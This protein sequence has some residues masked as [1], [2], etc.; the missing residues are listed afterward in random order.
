MSQ[1]P[2]ALFKQKYFCQ[3]CNRQCRDKD[4][5]NCHLKSDTHRINMEQVAENPDLYINNY[6][7]E[8]Q[9]GFLDILK[10]G[11]TNVW[12][13]ANKIYQEYIT[14]KFAT[15]LNATKWTTLT[16]FIKSMESKEKLEIK[17][18]EKEVLIR[19]REDQK[20][21]EKFLFQKKLLEQKN[22]E[23]KRNKELSKI[24]SRANEEKNKES[25]NLN[26]TQNEDLCPEKNLSDSKDDKIESLVDHEK[27]KNISIQLKINKS[28]EIMKKPI[29]GNIFEQPEFLCKKRNKD[30]IFGMQQENVST[31]V[32]INNQFNS[33]EKDNL[34]MENTKNLL[35]LKEPKSLQ[36]EIDLVNIPWIQKK[37]IVRIKDKDLPY[38][39]QKAK[40][41]TLIDDFVAEVKILNSPDIKIKIDQA[42]L[43]PV[44]PSAGKDSKVMIIFGEFKNILGIIEKIYVEEKHAYVILEDKNKLEDRKIK[45][46]LKQFCK[47]EN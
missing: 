17:S 39:N 8:F 2:G 9:R 47:Y 14:D 29:S 11:Y 12:V 21:D 5:F 44:I 34:V 24:L 46:N 35:K 23:I 7:Y 42:Y 26:Y 18:N 16:G 19:H 4:G 1:A 36:E 45:L 13:S 28:E 43:E 38:Y 15:H 33:K 27:L 31:K 25:K 30:E 20:P 40:V 41:E 3:M 10:R 6:S 22:E 37:L 32:S